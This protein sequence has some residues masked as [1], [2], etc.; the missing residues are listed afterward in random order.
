MVA[1][2]ICALITFGPSSSLPFVLWCSATPLTSELSPLCCVCLDGRVCRAVCV[3]V[4]VRVALCACL[5]GGGA[6]LSVCVLV[7]VRAVQCLA[8]VPGIIISSLARRSQVGSSG[9]RVVIP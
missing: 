2:I 8:S 6:C 4:L 7:V 1:V 9:Q 5:R 3:L